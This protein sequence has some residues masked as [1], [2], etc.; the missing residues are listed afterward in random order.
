MPVKKAKAKKEK[1]VVKQFE[2]GC[3]SNYAIFRAQDVKHIKNDVVRFDDYAEPFRGYKDLTKEMAGVIKV[4]L[5]R[6]IK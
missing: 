6:E 3:S 2:K 4:R 5:E 1:F